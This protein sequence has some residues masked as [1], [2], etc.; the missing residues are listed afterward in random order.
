MAE[1]FDKIFAKVVRETTKTALKRM[2]CFSVYPPPAEASLKRTKTAFMGVSG[3]ILR[4]VYEIF[5]KIRYF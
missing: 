5:Y 1:C 2:F 4:I 3:A